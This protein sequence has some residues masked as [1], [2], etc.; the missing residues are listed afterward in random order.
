VGDSI[1]QGVHV[2]GE[3]NYPAVLGRLLGE[4]YADGVHPNA[5]GC[6]VL[7]QAVFQA[8]APADAAE[9][10][11]RAAAA[12]A[13]ATQAN[14]EG[15]H[16]VQ[17]D[18]KP[19]A[20]VRFPSPVPQFTFASTLPEQEAELKT[21]PL[22]R[23]FA[24][25]RSK[26]ASDKHRPLYHFVSP[27][28]ML[29]DPNGLCYWQGRWHLFY[30]AYPPEDTRQHWGHTV[31]DDLIHWRDLPYAIYPGIERMCFS[32]STV[33]EDKQVV[34]FY[35][36]V[37][38]GM[39]AAISRDP[40]L[41]N[42]D[43]IPG[44]PVHK[45][46]VADS[47]IWKQG[48]TYLGLLGGGKVLSST[49]LT[50]WNLAN[51][52]F[53]SGSWPIDDANCPNFVPIGDKHLLLLFSHTRGGQYLLG[54]Y[55]P[56]ELKFMPYAHGRFNHGLV[57][58]AG[59]HAPSAASDGQGG[60]INILNINEGKSAN[61]WDHIF[62]LA[63]RLTLG[64][65][66][67]LR[68]APVAAVASLR[69]DGYRLGRTELAANQ[70]IVLDAVKGDSIELDVE[71]D[72][73][74][75]ASV[76]L[77]VFRSPNAEEQTTITLHNYDRHVN[78]WFHRRSVISLDSTRSSTLPDVLTRPPETAEFERG[79]EPLRLRVFLDR[80]VVEVFVNERLYLATR[81]Y[82]GRSDSTGVSFRAQGQ[83]AVLTRLNSWPMKSIWPWKPDEPAKKK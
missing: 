31:S 57:A 14:L 47:C 20:Q 40:L 74:S 60:V 27:E 36:G 30:Q 53:I 12:K 52:N 9:A 6:A 51:D 28:S 17:T 37:E 80:S 76:T 3:D 72:P 46:L 32:G 25:S 2:C 29:N 49:N 34:A 48:D 79:N 67:R 44:N 10:A 41:L 62:S 38:A 8:L 7:A 23:R 83:G 43:K 61:G 81:V 63:Q 4:R 65:D 68:L 11:R 35:P 13:R 16:I 18:V 45:T 54:D 64:P 26:L 66:K 56:G 15:C 77:S 71:I 69:G 22:L 19:A 33:V 24:E 50:N 82:P 78:P 73:K 21:N 1:T 59:V 58:P 42:W 55:L 75:A 39:M 70:E 5:A